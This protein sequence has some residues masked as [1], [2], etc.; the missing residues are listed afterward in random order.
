VK[1]LVVKTIFISALMFLCLAFSIL[2]ILSVS[3]PLN[4]SKFYANLGMKELSLDCS[5]IYYKASSDIN[6]QFTM[7]NQAVQ[8]K[9]YEYTKRYAKKLIDNEYLSDFV[10]YL[11]ELH[12]SNI[13]L[14]NEAN[15]IYQNYV[16]ALNNTKQKDNAIEFAFNN[17]EVQEANEKFC[18]AVYGLDKKVNF[19]SAQKTLI[20]DKYQELLD[21]FN[22]ETGLNK[23]VAAVRLSEMLSVI[24]RFE[25]QS[26]Y[27]NTFDLVKA[28][29]KLW[30]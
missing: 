4:M 25:E 11:N 28:E 6:D 29:L 5:H 26:K 9:N 16:E 12:P 13:Y 10:I 7:F 20:K 30:A 17:L 3:M 22:K 24:F 18:F 23:G 1:N 19:S 14:Q 8:A 15:R 27:Q 21:Y 2:G